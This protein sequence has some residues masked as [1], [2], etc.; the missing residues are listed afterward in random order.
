MELLMRPFRDEE[1][2]WA[3]RQFLRDVYLRNGQAEHSS[4]AQRFDYRRE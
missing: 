2:Y 3:I 1:D 4:Q